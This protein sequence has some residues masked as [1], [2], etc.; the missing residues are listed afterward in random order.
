M[1]KVLKRI[2]LA[3]L[4]I[5]IILIGW[6]ALQFHSLPEGQS[7]DK[8]DEVARKMLESVN[9]KAFKKIKKINW[10]FRDKSHHEW[11]KKA[12]TDRVRWGKNEVLLDFKSSNHAVVKGGG[13]FTNEELIEQA[14]AHF[15]NDSFWLAA[16]F[17]VMDEGVERQAVEWEDGYALRLTYT[18]GGNTPGDSYLWILDEYYR[19]VAWRLWTSNTSIKG[20]ELGWTDWQQLKGAWFAPI[21]PGPGPISIDITNLR[22][23]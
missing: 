8:A 4:F 3:L 15:Y 14:I 10:T 17:K 16:P 20:I 18:S 23:E 2:G 5:L 13:E 11:N 19:P 6:V 7:G 21:H 12:R 1:K 9:H 22:V